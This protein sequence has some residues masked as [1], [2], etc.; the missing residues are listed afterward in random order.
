VADVKRGVLVLEK[1]LAGKVKAWCGKRG[2]FYRR[3]ENLVGQGDPD[4]YMCVRGRHVWVELKTGTGLRNEQLNWMH[5]ATKSGV[6]H[7]A[8]KMKKSGEV[9]LFNEIEKVGSYPDLDSAL[10]QVWYEYLS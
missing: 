7:V 6:P 10:E 2:I 9:V 1:V 4:V 5:L 3:I 8:L